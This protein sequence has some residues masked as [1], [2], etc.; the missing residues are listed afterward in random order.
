MCVCVCVWQVS[1][2]W[3]RGEGHTVNDVINNK[4]KQYKPKA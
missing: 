4:R 3:G 2:C 1:V